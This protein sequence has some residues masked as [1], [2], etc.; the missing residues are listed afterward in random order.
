MIE[1]QPDPPE[2]GEQ[3][4]SNGHEDSSPGIGYE[5]YGDIQALVGPDFEPGDLSGSQP[6][7]N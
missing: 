2:P 4:S 3:P 6:S 5:V 7:E 1:R